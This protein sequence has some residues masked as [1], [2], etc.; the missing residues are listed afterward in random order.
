MTE[1]ALFMTFF[2]LLLFGFFVGI[3]TTMLIQNVTN[4]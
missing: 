2:V 4:S 3:V 1:I